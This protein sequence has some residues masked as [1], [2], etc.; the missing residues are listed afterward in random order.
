[1]TATNTCIFSVRTHIPLRPYHQRVSI[2]SAFFSASNLLVQFS[3]QFVD[4]TLCCRLWPSGTHENSNWTIGI[5]E[6][7]SRTHIQ[8]FFEMCMCNNI[9]HSARST[10]MCTADIGNFPII[11]SIPTLSVCVIVYRSVYRNA[12]N[13]IRLRYFIIV[14]YG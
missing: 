14:M 6:A 1:M 9:F 8:W 12:L 2:L 5:N 3:V 4:D 7:D 11:F 10:L 13:I